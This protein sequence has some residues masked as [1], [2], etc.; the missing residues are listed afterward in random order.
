QSSGGSSPRVIYTDA[1]GRF[2]ITGL[3][4]DDYDLRAS[5]NGFYSDWER[6]IVARI[7]QPREVI[8]KLVNKD[9]PPGQ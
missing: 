2:T 8:M 5:A 6:N 4:Q 3:R 7:G 9:A 1:N